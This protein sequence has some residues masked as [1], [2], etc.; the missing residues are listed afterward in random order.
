[1][2]YV[3]IGFV[4]RSCQILVVFYWIVY[5]LPQKHLQ[6]IY[7]IR[8]FVFVCEFLPEINKRIFI[9]MFRFSSDFWNEYA[10]ISAG[11]MSFLFAGD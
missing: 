9:R 1:M 7:F 5:V 8:E 11:E 3:A 4:E 6:N 2:E 10:I